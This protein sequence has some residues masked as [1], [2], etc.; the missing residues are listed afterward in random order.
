M[1]QLNAVRLMY[2]GL[3]A[4]NFEILLEIVLDK[5]VGEND[6]RLGIFGTLAAYGLAVEEQGRKTLHCH[7]IVYTTDWNQLLRGLHSCNDRVRKSSEKKIV[8]FVD[9]VLSTELV[10]KS[11]IIQKCPTCKEGVLVYSEG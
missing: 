11:H 7:I 1:E 2:P 3:C 10:P 6:L 9:S 4:L 8:E 5:I